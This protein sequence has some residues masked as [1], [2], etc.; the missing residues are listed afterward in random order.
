ME[1]DHA[2][3][4]ALVEHWRPEMHTFH[5]PHGEMGITFQDI[6][7]M[8]GVP[9]DG[10]P[11]TGSVKPKWPALCHVLLGHLPLD[12]IPHPHE[13]MSILARA[14]LKVSWLKE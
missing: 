11:V 13:N 14:R 3:I 9:V 2:L 10:L 12:P 1:V 4:T 6:E 5:L 8:L 7:V